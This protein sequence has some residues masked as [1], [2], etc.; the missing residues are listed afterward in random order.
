MNR[1]PASGDRLNGSPDVIGSAL[2]RPGAAIGYHAGRIL[3]ERCAYLKYWNQ[4]QAPELRLSAAGI[5]AVAAVTDS[6]SFAYLK[7][8]C[9]SATMAWVNSDKTLPM[10][11]IALAQAKMLE[12]QRQSVPTKDEVPAAPSRADQIRDLLMG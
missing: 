2:D 1:A 8:L 3:R 7:E 12:E 4:L 11:T 5:E 9:L 6:F 10:D